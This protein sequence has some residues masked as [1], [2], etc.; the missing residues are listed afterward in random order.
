ME[1]ESVTLIELPVPNQLAALGSGSVDAVLTLE[2]TGTLGEQKGVARILSANPMVRFV[3]DPW[4]GGAGVVS[5]KFLERNPEKAKIFLKVMAKAIAETENNPETRQY[6]VK[7]LD[8]PQSVAEKVP[9]PVMVLSG[10]ADA[11]TVKAYQQFA[12]TFFE[13]G[14]VQEKPDVAGLLL[15]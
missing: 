12:D 5:S 10:D 15:R 9:L 1:P 3:S 6:L 8:L 4:C 11:K 14:V 7:Y 13:F 2:P